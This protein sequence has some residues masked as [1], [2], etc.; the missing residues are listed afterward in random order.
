MLG[1]TLLYWP[2][3]LSNNMKT[4]QITEDYWLRKGADVIASFS[5]TMAVNAVRE[6]SRKGLMLVT[7][8]RRWQIINIMNSFWTLHCG[9]LGFDAAYHCRWLQMFRRNV[10]PLTSGQKSST[11]KRE[12]A[13]SSKASVTTYKIAWRHNAEGHNRC[14]RQCET[15][16][17]F[18]ELFMKNL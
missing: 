4:S 1:F 11:T 17:I 5:A 7:L 8:S 18:S 13:I 6:L 16:I 12:E 15:Q 9:H 14:L 3:I 2:K 10:S